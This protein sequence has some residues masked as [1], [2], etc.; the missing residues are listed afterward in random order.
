MSDRPRTYRFSVRRL[1]IAPAVI[2]SLLWL[3]QATEPIHL[4]VLG[5]VSVAVV[6][7]L[8]L[9]NRSDTRTLW[10]VVGTMCGAAI[11]YHI[12]CRISATH[13]YRWAYKQETI[14]WYSHI[15][16]GIGAIVAAVMLWARDVSD[17]MYTHSPWIVDPRVFWGTLSIVS[18][19]LY[20]TAPF[21]YVR[22]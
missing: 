3:T 21:N 8:L 4:T 15:C 14:L 7:V 6:A 9:V 20:F 11:G 10:I 2:L 18:A 5:L 22:E 13:Q 17:A 1:L 19:F 16:A 12:A